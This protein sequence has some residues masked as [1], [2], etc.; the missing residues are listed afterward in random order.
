VGPGGVELGDDRGL[1]STA[2]F[3]SGPE[4]CSAR[5]DYDGVVSV[6][7]SHHVPRAGLKVTITAVPMI[8]RVAVRA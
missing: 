7:L 3:E 5:S 1:D 8:I 6:D 2:G 4:P